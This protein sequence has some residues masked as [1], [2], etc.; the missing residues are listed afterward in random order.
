MSSAEGVIYK[1]RRENFPIASR[2][3]PRGYR[4]HLIRV[5][6]FA[7]LVDDIGDEVAPGDRLRLLDVVEEELDRLY[8]GLEPRL[9]A[10]RDLG[11]TIED[12]RIPAEP[13]KRLI[14]AGR[15]DQVVTRYDTFEELLGYCEQ[16]ANPIGRITLYV[17]GA[18]DPARCLLSDRICSALEVI[19]RC[20]GVGDDYTRG[21]IYLPRKD[22]MRYG[23]TEDDFVA[24]TTPARL[25]RVVARQAERAARLLDEGTPLVASLVGPARTA[26]AG[27]VAGGRAALAALA[28]A[29]HDVLGRTVRPGRARRLALWVRVIA[30]GR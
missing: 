13:F 23:C 19:E 1:G 27:Y 6:G 28:R 20:Q 30:T 2:L 11:E 22:L 18:A 5:H 24:A 21:R 17:F 8:A 10:I 29:H 26:T 7:R 4:R 14:R 3:L 15:Q 12:R 9:P 25:R 16:A